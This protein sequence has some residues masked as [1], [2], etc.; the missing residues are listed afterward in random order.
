MYRLPT[1]V[2]VVQDVSGMGI[3]PQNPVLPMVKEVRQT[4]EVKEVAAMLS[5][6][7]WVAIAATMGGD[8]K[9]LF[10]LGRVN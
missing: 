8:G 5:S 7:D 9:C 4:T 3:K 1:K 2:G 10:A 6:G